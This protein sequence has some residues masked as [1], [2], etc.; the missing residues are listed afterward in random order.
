MV[1]VVA[2]LLFF[3]NLPNTG[4]QFHH[5]VT[6]TNWLLTIWTYIT[7]TKWIHYM[8]HQ[9]WNQHTEQCKQQQKNSNNKQIQ[10]CVLVL[11]MFFCLFCL[12]HTHPARSQ[13]S[14]DWREHISAT[15]TPNPLIAEQMLWRNGRNGKLP[16]SQPFQYACGYPHIK[17]RHRAA[18]WDR[19]YSYILFL[20]ASSFACGYGWIY[21]N[22]LWEEYNQWTKQEYSQEREERIKKISQHKR[23]I[24]ITI[25]LNIYMWMLWVSGASGDGSSSASDRIIFRFNG[26]S[27][28]PYCNITWLCGVVLRV[29]IECR[30]CRYWRITP[31][32]QTQ[33]IGLGRWAIAKEESLILIWCDY[34]I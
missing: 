11:A 3:F 14:R 34:I 19:I 27:G 17:P 21:S 9:Q 6:H 13:S 25:K 15:H 10:Y 8:M 5:S 20:F 30:Y 7:A 26:R 23:K 24:M 31:K 16:F 18:N 12:R 1:G 22:T 32:T 2:A 28:G 4:A 29:N 33:H